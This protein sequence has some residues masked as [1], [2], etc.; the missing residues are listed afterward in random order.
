MQNGQES[1]QINIYLVLIIF[2]KA[3]IEDIRVTMCA[4][5][6]RASVIVMTGQEKDKKSSNVLNRC[7]HV[8]SYLRR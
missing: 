5:P 4:R 3:P 7:P 6:V 8:R 1:L 2:R